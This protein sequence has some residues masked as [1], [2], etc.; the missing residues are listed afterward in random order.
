MSEQLYLTV[1]TDVGAAKIAAAI[2][3]GKPYFITEAAVGD[4]AGAYYRPTPQ[5]I[6]LR[7]EKWR[8]PIV[9]KETNLN[10]P[11]VIKVKFIVPADIGGFTV[12][13]A[14]LF[15]AD[16][17]MLAVCN[18]PDTQKVQYTSGTTGKLTVTMHI[19]VTDSGTMEFIVHPELD[20]VAPEQLA[21]AIAAH[22]QKDDS[23]PQILSKI[24]D[25]SA[26]VGYV[27]DGIFGVEADFTNNRF[28]RLAGA[29]GRTPGVDFN[30]V[31]AFGGRR[32]CNLTD[33]GVVTAYYGDPAYTEVGKLTQAVTVGGTIYPIGTAV[34]VMVEQPKFYYRVV[35][36][37]TDRVQDGK[38][39]HLRKARYYVAD[40]PKTGFKL[41][42]AFLSA[43]VEKDRIYL[44]A[45][46]GCLFDVSANAY[47]LDDAQVA[48]FTVSTGD[49]ISSVANAKPMSGLTQ[50]LTR[51]NTRRLAQ[52]R[53]TGWQQSYAATAAA[54]ELLFIIEY[55]GFN[56]QN[57]IGIGVTNKT[58]DTTSN[59]SEPTGTSSPLGNTSGSLDNIRGWNIVSYRGEENFWGNIWTWV[60]GMNIDA[61][62]RHELYIADSAF[63]DDT[64]AGTYKN[65]GI[66]LAKANGYISAF[67]Y[68]EPFDW[69]FMPSET[70]GNSALPVGDYFYQNNAYAGFLVAL[71]GGSW[72]NGA[73]AGGF[74]WLVA[75]ASS[76]RN[77]YVGGRP[78][79]VPTA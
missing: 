46:E 14:G 38:G 3:S 69:L 6:E 71:L 79:Y 74:C 37:E 18:M 28:E 66:T 54:T 56:T 58:D 40:T 60:D 68:N 5:Q 11:D 32:R 33:A 49:K 63:T 12:R 26:Y 25:L 78:V 65:A 20:N 15:D 72:N 29:A 70:L 16:G 44:A 73:N 47:I 42:P 34:Q 77:R 2:Q 52:N 24:S 67:A 9:S 4:G 64:T 75:N 27:E 41:H 50:S 30:S 36:L 48:D 39:Y 22:D 19:I 13:E 43:G 59:M 7:G 76:H 57:S 35:P 51:A 45:Y 21:A 62:G 31:Q 23:H 8:G 10:E 55:A 61:N 17:D 53:G 1:I